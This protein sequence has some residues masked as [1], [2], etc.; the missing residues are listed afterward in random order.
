MQTFYSKR[1]RLWLLVTMAILVALGTIGMG[2]NMVNADSGQWAPLKGSYSGT[3]AFT[4][5]TTAFLSGTGHATLLG[6]G[7]YAGDVSEITLTPTGLTDVLVA[8]LAAANGDTLT[9]TC[10]GA[11][12]QTSP[13]VFQGARQCVVTGGTGRFLGATGSGTADSLVD[14][15]HGTFSQQ[16]T[17]TI[18]AP[19]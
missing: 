3:I 1:S 14:V 6:R 19:P 4:G 15:N 12:T 5:P 10:P 7:P 16:L 11:A 9:L 2:A 17:G 13:G 8:T 18:S